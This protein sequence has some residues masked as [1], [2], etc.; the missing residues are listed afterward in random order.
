MSG[1]WGYVAASYSLVLGGLAA[2]AARTVRR[3]RRLARQV[4]AADRTWA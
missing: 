4:P 1:Q 2:Y 3:S